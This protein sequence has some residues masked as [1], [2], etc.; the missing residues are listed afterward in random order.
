MDGNG[1][2][3]RRTVSSGGGWA[4][5]FVANSFKARLPGGPP[6]QVFILATAAAAHATIWILREAP[7]FPEGA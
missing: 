2:A 1:G 6:R 4:A 7:S 3:N 5:W